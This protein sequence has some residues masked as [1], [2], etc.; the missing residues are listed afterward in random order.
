MGQYIHTKNT[1]D[2]IRYRIW[3]SGVSG[4]TTP[5]MTKQ[6]ITQALVESALDYTLVTLG[7]H[8]T[9]RLQRAVERGTSSQLHGCER[10]NQDWDTQA[11]EWEPDEPQADPQEFLGGTVTTIL[12]GEPHKLDSK[13]LEIDGRHLKVTYTVEL[14]T[15]IEY[16]KH[17][18]EGRDE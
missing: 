6:E 4:Y 2:G 9:K 10:L 8:T 1:P 15:P 16:Q 12:A 14:I 3:C 7:I 5:E 18:P 13:P 11:P 17:N